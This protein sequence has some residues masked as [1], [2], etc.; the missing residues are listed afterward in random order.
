MID[1][2]VEF[3]INS[4]STNIMQYPIKTTSVELAIKNC[5]YFYPNSIITNVYMKVL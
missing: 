3:K 5:Q 2:M 4:S 1:Y